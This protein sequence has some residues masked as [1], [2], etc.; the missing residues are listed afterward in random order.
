LRF[1][2]KRHR[3]CKLLVVG[4]ILV[5]CS[6]L[7][8]SEKAEL[9]ST[10]VVRYS[11]FDSEKLRAMYEIDFIFKKCPDFYVVYCSPT[12]KKMAAD[13]YDATIAWA[14]SVMSN[15]FN[16]EL[17]IRNVETAMSI[18]GKKGQILFTPMNGWSFDQD[19]YYESSKISATTLRVR[20]WKLLKPALKV[21]T[22]QTNSSLDTN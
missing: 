19:W 9:M 4:L 16:G 21:K 5:A 17:I 15:S 3:N 1:R 8:G 7:F 22:P 6:N 13:F 12:E 11:G 18:T 20:M 14:D 10:P 2:I